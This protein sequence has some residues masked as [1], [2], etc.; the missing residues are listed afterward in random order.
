MG[1]LREERSLVRGGDGRVCWRAAG[2][3]LLLAGLHS[4]WQIRRVLMLVLLLGE[5]N[6]GGDCSRW[7]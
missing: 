1:R 5:G 2:D 4:S 6:A 7:L 3:G